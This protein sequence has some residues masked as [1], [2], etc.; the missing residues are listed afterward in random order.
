MLQALAEP[1]RLALKKVGISIKEVRSLGRLLHIPEEQA[2]LWLHLA[3]GLDLIEARH[4]WWRPSKQAAAWGR[5]GAR[6]PASRSR[7]RPP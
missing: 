3:D 4:G 5:G 6:R 1:S 7:P 2:R